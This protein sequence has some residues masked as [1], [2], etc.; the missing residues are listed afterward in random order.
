MILERSS[1]EPRSRARNIPPL[2]LSSGHRDQRPAVG[3]TSLHTS[4]PGGVC[5]STLHAG[6]VAPMRATILSRVSSGFLLWASMGGNHKLV[7]VGGLRLGVPWSPAGRSGVHRVRSPAHKPAIRLL[8]FFSQTKATLIVTR[9]VA[10]KP[11]GAAERGPHEKGTILGRKL[12]HRQRAQLINAHGGVM[13]FCRPLHFLCGV[14]PRGVGG[15]N[16]S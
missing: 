3:S 16:N 15:L 11:P 5:R 6:P 2:P 12:S 8:F 1:W 4:Q 7:N 10:A 14:A 13:V 9:T